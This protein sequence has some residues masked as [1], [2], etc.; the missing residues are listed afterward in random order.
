[1]APSREEL[2]SLARG[3]SFEIPDHE[4]EDY[5]VLLARTEK[6]LETVAAMDGK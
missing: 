4:I 1:M 5:E 2:L 6:T 3:L